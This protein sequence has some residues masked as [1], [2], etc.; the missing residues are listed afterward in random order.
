MMSHRKT[1]K[2]SANLSE[3]PR[4]NW[5]STEKLL[6][7]LI[8]PMNSCGVIKDYEYSILIVAT[9]LLIMEYYELLGK[10]TITL[11]E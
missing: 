4:Y 10:I 1:R 11:L 3:F 2:K 8:F 7:K 6:D 9:E 5:T